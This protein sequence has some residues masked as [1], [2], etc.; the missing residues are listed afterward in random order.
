MAGISTKS[1]YGLAAAFELAQNY[2]KSH[3][4]IKEIS[5]KLGIPQNYLEQ[6]LATLKK[7]GIVESVRGAG[8][9]Y[10]LSKEPSEICCA[11]VIEA[12]DGEVWRI[13]NPLSNEALQLFWQ[14]MGE[15]FKKKY[16]ISLKELLG[17]NDRAALSITYHI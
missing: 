8:G 17:Y 13:E 14:E 4:Q 10:R 9:G 15:G 5:Q 16:E 3:I 2:G 11:K 7:A 6:L 12:L 1:I